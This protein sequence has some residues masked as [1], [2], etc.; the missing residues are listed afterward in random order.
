[1]RLGLAQQADEQR[2]LLLHRG[3]VDDLAHAVDRDLVR[4]DAHQLRIVHVLVGELEHPLR[5]RRRKQHRLAPLRRA[6]GGA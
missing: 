1:M 3:E 2:H 5:E 6:A 4:L